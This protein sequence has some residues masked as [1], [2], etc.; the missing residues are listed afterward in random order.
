MLDVVVIPW[1]LD[2]PKNSISLPLK[3]RLKNCLKLLLGSV[4]ELVGNN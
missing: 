2:R 4:L 1:F 3:I